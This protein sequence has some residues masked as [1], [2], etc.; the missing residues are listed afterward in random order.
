MICDGLITFFAKS[1]RGSLV[2]VSKVD[3]TEK[4]EG[5]SA[6]Q[7]TLHRI[8]YGRSSPIRHAKAECTPIRYAMKGAF[9]YDSQCLAV[10]SQ[11][12]ALT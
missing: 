10:N 1:I 11:C 2:P 7:C 6:I 4:S 3:K 12:L 9:P 5:I 8:S